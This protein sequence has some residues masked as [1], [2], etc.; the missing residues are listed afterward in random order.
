MLWRVRIWV[1]AVAI[2]MVVAVAASL[3]GQFLPFVPYAAW[4]VYVGGLITAGLI[5]NALWKPKIR[6]VLLD[7]R[8]GPPEQAG[9]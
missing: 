2:F 5:V 1:Y 8:A 3:A 9:R 4:I 7:V 6:V